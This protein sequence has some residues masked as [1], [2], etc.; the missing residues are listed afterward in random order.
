MFEN[1]A[2]RW[3]KVLRDA[4]LNKART[5]L[6]VLAITLGMVAAGALL[7]AWALVRRVTL[8]T[9]A[10]SHPASASLLVDAP[11]N[12]ALLAQIN[13]L[14]GIAAARM[15]GHAFATLEIRGTRQPAELFALDDFTQRSIAAVDAARGTWPTDG[16]IAIEKSSLEFSNASLDAD[17]EVKRGASMQRLR[18]SGVAHDVGLPPGWM[19]HVVYGFVTPATLAALGV[20]P[21]RNELQFVV[22]DASLDRDAVR[23]LAA[24][25]KVL[26]NHNGVGVGHVEVPVPGQHPHAA[27]MDSLM[28]TQ[29]AFGALTLLVVC[30]LIVNLINAMLAG[31]ARQIGVMK[32]LGGS[33]HQIASLYLA[34]ALMLGVVASAL[35]LPAALAIG[36][37]YAALKADMLNFSI[38]GFS[39]PWWAV[40]LQ[41]AVGCLLPVLAAAWPVMRACRV[42]VA[43]ALHDAG[44]D[45]EHGAYLRP[46]NTLPGVSR[47]L[48]LSKANAFRRRQR[49]LLTLL[50]LA[51]GGAVFVGADNLRGA[52][53]GSVER[54]FAAQR[55]DVMLRFATAHP[56]K[57][58]EAAAARVDGVVSAQAL[59]ADSATVVRADGETGDAFTLLGV[60]PDTPLFHASIDRGRWLGVQDDKVLVLSQRL[61]REQ[62]QLKIDGDAV[63]NIGGK[64]STWHIIGADQTVVQSV[65]YAPFATLAALHGDERAATLAIAM[66]GGDAAAKL[67]VIM[68]LRAALDQQEL[69]VADS[70]LLSETRRA[71][72]DH[73][74]M[75]W[76]FLSAMGWVM[77][78]VGGMGLSSTMSI[79][80]LERTREIGVLRAIGARHGAIMRMIQIEGL[81]IVVLAWFVSLVLSAPISVLLGA[82][83]GR[84]MF[85]VPVRLLPSAS[86][87]L[88]W[89]V[90]SF[91]LSLVACAWPGRRAMRVPAARALNYE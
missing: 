30:F 43:T 19:D 60:P 63:L 21:A 31:Q 59:L 29:G 88:I 58:L 64:T 56:A 11:V 82:A 23:R 15:R 18:V 86:A 51:L 20:M 40:A 70:Q 37:P 2:P 46:R 52:V 10:A 53:L 47:P 25:V 79:A 74:L 78:A 33:T 28:F 44:I 6:V 3:R 26:L 22:R 55:Y 45:A 76:Q 1:I 77:I 41:I 13:A 32:A 85:P 16:E 89:L 66:R 72:E 7:D 17:I 54:M 35:A 69:R 57:D 5:L 71:V 42:R 65:A 73:L 36:R 80:V 12:D 27:Q 87:A 9:Y 39:I 14:P 90:L 50:S 67:D 24:E 8:E 34:F 38:A 84:I 49:T 4:G 48:M 81:V 61:L 62:P 75:V 83:F 68:R 91:T